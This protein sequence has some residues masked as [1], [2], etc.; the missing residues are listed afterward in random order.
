MVIAS[1]GNSDDDDN[2]TP[3]TGDDFDAISGNFYEIYLLRTPYIAA[4]ITESQEQDRITE[5]ESMCRKI[6]HHSYH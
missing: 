3:P 5:R 6:R 1:G 4:V 2:V